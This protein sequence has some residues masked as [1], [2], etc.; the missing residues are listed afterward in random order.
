MPKLGTRRLKMVSAL[1]S[2][3]N[4]VRRRQIRTSSFHPRASASPWE[5]CT[6]ELGAKPS[7]SCV[8]FWGFRAL[9]SV[10]SK[11]VL[12]AY[13]SLVETNPANA[14]LDI[15]NAILIQKDFEILDQYRND[16]VNYF[17]AEARAVDFVRDGSRVTAEINEWVKDKT[18]GK[19][20]KLLDKALPMNTVAFLINAVYFK[21][22]WVTKFQARN[23]KPLSFYNQGRDEVRV[24]TMSVRRHFGY[25]AVGELNA[26]A[27]EVP[28]AGNRFSMII[29]LPNSRTGLA[30]VVAHLTTHLVDTITND[31]WQSDVQ[32]WLPKFK[33]QTD[34]DLVAPL[35]R[36]GLK[37]AFG[38]S[39][40]FSGISSRN[41]LAVSD[42]K[43]KA[44]VEVSE[45]GTVAAAVTSVRIVRKSARS[46]GPRPPIPFRVEH[47][48]VF[49]IWD[50]VSK[51]ALFIGVVRSLNGSVNTRAYNKV[52][53]TFPTS[54]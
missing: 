48:F 3:R 45:E 10:A 8:P 54:V 21:G 4:S 12:S 19:I 37:S 17:Q 51:Q 38:N 2:S 6:P 41:D 13:K 7:K 50:K 20:P 46:A 29:V 42:V 35:R 22:T 15:A 16:V 43:H 32:L 9:V 31:L 27:L 23:T 26:R 33:L 11:A 28:Y 49:F 1:P 5:C 47:P 40:N 52:S 44:M 36:L 34:Y 30:K 25:A 53:Q 18:K 14:T 39:A 24:A